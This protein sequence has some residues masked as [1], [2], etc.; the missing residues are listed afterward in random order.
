MVNIAFFSVLA[1]RLG[2]PV[3]GLNFPEL[4]GRLVVVEETQQ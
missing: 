2:G 3:E 4:R 1:A